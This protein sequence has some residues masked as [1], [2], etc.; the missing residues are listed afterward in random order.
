MIRF[1]K[2]LD[3]RNL[4]G[5][6]IGVSKGENTLSILEELKVVKLFLVD[7]YMPF[8]EDEIPRN[9]GDYKDSTIHKLADYPQVR[10]ILKPSDEAATEI[11]DTL[12]F[13]Y[14]DGNHTYKYIKN[15]IQLYYPK[16]KP[17]GVIGGHDYTRNSRGVMQAVDEFAKAHGYVHD[18]DFFTIFPDWWLIKTR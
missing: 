3:Q 11:D 15:D 1:L 2:N 17:H 14:I 12:D 16:V 18:I 5:V 7:P 8:S 13:V 6:E 9:H 10:W 4:V